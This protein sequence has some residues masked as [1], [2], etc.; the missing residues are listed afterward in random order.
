MEDVAE[1]INEMQRIHD[2]YGQSFDELSRYCKR[3]VDT[4][5]RI[6][7]HSTCTYVV[8]VLLLVALYHINLLGSICC[9]FFW[10]QSYSSDFAF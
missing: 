4:A 8:L 10:R 5:V 7:E 9:I 3:A 6:Y 1:H 2:E